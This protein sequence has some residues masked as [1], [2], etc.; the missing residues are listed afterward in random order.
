M[1]DF[2]SE[3]GCCFQSAYNNS[4]YNRQILIAGFITQSEFI[5]IQELGNPIGNPW[6][7]CDIESP[8]RCSPPPFKPPPRPKCTL[9]DQTAFISTLPNAAVC[10]ASIAAVFTRPA[11]D[12]TA[13]ASAL[14]NVCENDCGGVYA[15]Y[16]DSTCDDKI[17]AETLRIYCTPTNGSADTGS[18]CR[19]AADDLVGPALFN[20]LSSCDESDT[21]SSECR[22]AVLNFE[23]EVGCC[24][25]NGY[26]NS[27]YN[28]QILNAGFITQS[29]FI[30]IQKLGNPLKN[31][32]T[33]CGIKPPQR[34][35][36]PPFRPPPRPRC[37]R[38]DQNAFIASLLNPRECG[39]SIATVFF[40]PSNDSD[41]KLLR[42]ALEMFVQMTVQ[43]FIPST[44]NQLVTINLE[45]NPLGYFALQLTDQLKLETCV[46]L[47]LWTS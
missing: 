23:S 42:K 34:C 46:V 13:L 37:N 32:W 38:E 31:P 19:L 25:Q 41:S 26:N 18:Y 2:Q 15:N 40:P 33:F 43:V 24:F 28:R 29:E 36:P 1:L 21:C 47:L 20:N 6:T 7:F 8:Q 10:G 4:E 30:A 14:K 16:L 5:D 22:R 12:T 39:L 44:W 3:V 9:E 35:G 17:G 27:E 11:N 45:L